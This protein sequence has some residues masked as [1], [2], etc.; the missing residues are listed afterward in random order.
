MTMEPHDVS[1]A[2]D[3]NWF[4]G[5]TKP[6]R[7]RD[8]EYDHLAEGK[9]WWIQPP[10]HQEIYSMKN[11]GEVTNQIVGIECVTYIYV[12]LVVLTILKN[13]KVDG[14]DYPIYYGK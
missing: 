13:M 5:F 6:P 10:K 9:I 14:K 2:Q 12:W 8:Q 11:D 7:R 1:R 4:M 3:A